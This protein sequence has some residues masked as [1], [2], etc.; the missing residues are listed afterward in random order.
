[1]TRVRLSGAAYA[2]LR[3]DHIPAAVYGL[4][5]LPA[6]PQATD[7]WAEV[8]EQWRVAL[9]VDCLTRWG[10]VASRVHPV[11]VLARRLALTPMEVP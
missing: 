8:T 1:M 3:L 4:R 11:A 6:A 5:L 2:L 10:A 9:T 7:R